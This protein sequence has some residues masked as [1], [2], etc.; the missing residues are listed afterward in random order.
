M[1]IAGVIDDRRHDAGVRREALLDEA[2]R[3]TD[4]HVGSLSGPVTT[5]RGVAA[6]S[7]PLR[8]RRS[9]QLRRYARQAHPLIAHAYRRRASEVE[10]EAWLRRLAT[11]RPAESA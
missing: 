8:T 4:V 2:G 3:I 11:T 7:M 1:T 9:R 10:F 6:N 5:E